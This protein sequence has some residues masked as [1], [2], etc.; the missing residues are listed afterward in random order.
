VTHVADA[1]DADAIERVREL[2]LEYEASLRADF[3]YQGAPAPHDRLPGEFAPPS[4]A[5]F[6]ATVDGA[7]AGCVALRRLRE[8]LCEM[9]HLYVRPAY[10]AHGLGIALVGAVIQRG[11]ELAY[12]ELWLDTLPTMHGAH[13]LYVRLGF[14]E[15]PAYGQAAPGSRFYGLRLVDQ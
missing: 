6:L 4:G 8:G 7:P 13:R 1:I 14:R 3:A 2:L 11:R 12:R 5:L 10:R 9:K 15:I